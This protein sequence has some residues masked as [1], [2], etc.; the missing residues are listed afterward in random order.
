MPLSET[1]HRLFDAF[2]AHDLELIGAYLRDELQVSGNITRPMGKPEFLTLLGAYFSAFPDFDFN[3]TEADQTGKTVRAKY[4]ISG[5]H[6]RKLDLNPIGTA[7]TVEP[8]GTAIRLPQ[9]VLEFT[10]DQD[11]LVAALVLH[12]APGAAMPDL[13]AKLGAA[14]PQ[15]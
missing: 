14:L 2:D 4:A 1:A 12:Q 13:L 15:E 3:F 7:V 10:L 9:S 8:T 5:T 6:Q 11:G